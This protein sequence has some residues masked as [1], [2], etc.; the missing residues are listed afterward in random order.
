VK[1]GWP[2]SSSCAPRASPCSR[3]AGTTPLA[4]RQKKIKASTSACLHLL[5]LPSTSSFSSF[6]SVLPAPP[7]PSLHPSTTKTNRAVGLLF[8]PRCPLPEAPLTRCPAPYSR[9][10]TEYCTM[11]LCELSVLSLAPDPSRGEDTRPPTC[12]PTPSFHS[13]PGLQ[14]P[15]PLNDVGASAS[16]G[17]LSKRKGHGPTRYP[18]SDLSI[19]TAGLGAL[20]V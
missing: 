5:F 17:C 8:R 9:P 13:G 1:S 7:S 4:A 3:P 6:P 14:R 11:V 2:S 18:E 15:P 19:A 16:K 10:R 20:P 12:T